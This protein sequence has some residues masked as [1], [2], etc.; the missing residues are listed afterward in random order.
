MS[1]VAVGALHQPF[2][3]AVVKWPGK[4]SADIQ[5]ARVTEFRRGLFEQKLAFS[6]MVRGVAIDAGDSALQ[7]GRAAKIVLLM[8]VGVTVQAARTDL[9][10]RRV[11][12]SKDLG[13]VPAPIHVRLTGAMA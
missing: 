12:E 8:A 4:L 7:M 3:D 11:L 1:I 13:L 10:R 6:C 9:H 5:M 2:V